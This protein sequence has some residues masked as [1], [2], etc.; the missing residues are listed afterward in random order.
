MDNN[1]VLHTAWGLC[2]NIVDLTARLSTV[3]HQYCGRANISK[4]DGVR[5][6]PVDVVHQAFRVGKAIL[7]QT[8]KE[9]TEDNW[10]R[11]ESIL[12]VTITCL[13]VVPP[14]VC[15]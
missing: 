13:K 1:S 8:F 2:S 9:I 6:M 7:L 15:F 4:W 12:E 10:E 5:G 3:F 11:Y 14:V